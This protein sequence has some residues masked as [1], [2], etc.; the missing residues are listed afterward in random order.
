MCWIVYFD[1]KRK[2][3]HLLIS[4]VWPFKHKK[5]VKFIYKTETKNLLVHRHTIEVKLWIDK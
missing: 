1:L 4:S 3:S 5:T 2:E